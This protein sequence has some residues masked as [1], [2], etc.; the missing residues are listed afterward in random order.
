MQR[1]AVDREQAKRVGN[2]AAEF[3]AQLPRPEEESR[4]DNIALLQWAAK[5]N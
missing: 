1:Y 4:A 2:L 3:L 5:L